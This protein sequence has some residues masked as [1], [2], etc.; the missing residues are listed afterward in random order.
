LKPITKLEGF[1]IQDQPSDIFR[2][3]MQ[4]SNQIKLASL[5]SQSTNSGDKVVS[6]STLYREIHRM[7]LIEQAQNKA[8]TEALEQVMADEWQFM[9]Y[10]E[11]ELA[12]ADQVIAEEMKFRQDVEDAAAE[13][14]EKLPGKNGNNVIVADHDNEPAIS[15]VIENM[16]IPGSPRAVNHQAGTTLSPGF[17]AYFKAS[18]D[19]VVPSVPTVQRAR[20]T[21]RTGSFVKKPRSRQNVYKY[22]WY[23]SIATTR[24]IDPDEEDDVTWEELPCFRL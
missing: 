14:S 17:D 11:D 9:K 16:I 5:S 12:A 4:N 20:R 24:T 21:K 18:F 15:D 8:E 10:M 19:S 22:P 23:L 3:I 13:V 2:F 6:K 7:K 1:N